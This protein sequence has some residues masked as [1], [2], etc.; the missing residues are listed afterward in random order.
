MSD[1][2][3]YKRFETSV[4]STNRIKGCILK[5]Q[6]V[7]TQ[8]DFS[9]IFQEMDHVNTEHPYIIENLI[10]QEDIIQDQ[11]IREFGDICSPLKETEYPVGYITFT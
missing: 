10:K 8:N 11:T 5:R 9:I 2:N 4:R 7:E 3:R 6:I 1:S